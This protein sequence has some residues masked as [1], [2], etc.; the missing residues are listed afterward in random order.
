LVGL[1]ASSS[2]SK[3]A[4]SALGATFPCVTL[5]PSG[6]QAGEMP[7]YLELF[8]AAR[9]GNIEEVQRLIEAGANIEEK[10]EVSDG[11]ATSVA[12]VCFSGV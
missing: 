6:A 12:A 9:G 8:T 11:A 3:G 10:N 7:T 4:C 2:S 1:L 5:S